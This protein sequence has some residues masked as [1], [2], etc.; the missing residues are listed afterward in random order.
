M[1]KPGLI[2]ACSLM[3]AGTVLA[4]APVAF[5]ARTASSGNWSDARTWEGGRKPQAGD[6]VGT[7]SV[8]RPGARDVKIV[9]DK[10]VP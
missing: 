10:V 5:N 8:V 4:A 6:I 3:F 7:S 9:L 1:L 2:L